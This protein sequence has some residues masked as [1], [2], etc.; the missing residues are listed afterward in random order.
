MPTVL[1]S[2]FLFPVY[3]MTERYR[4]LSVVFPGRYFTEIA[5][6]IALRGQTF[7]DLW[8]QIG[9][10]SLITLVLLVVAMSRFHRRMG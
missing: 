1:F 2:G 7:S 3:S 8:T 9:L 10:L 4:V 5:R 6:G